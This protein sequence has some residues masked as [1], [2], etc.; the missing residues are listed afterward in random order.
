M[1]TKLTREAFSENVRLHREKTDVH[2]EQ[3]L[4]LLLTKLET[5]STLGKL[6]V[7]IPLGEFPVLDTQ[8]DYFERRL[9]ELKFIYGVRWS[10]PF[11][12][13]CVLIEPCTKYH[14][15]SFLLV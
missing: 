4:N 5:A 12:C 1:T 10:H 13:D 15:I 14:V 11:Q 7:S 9:K 2:K 3:V 8:T 6:E